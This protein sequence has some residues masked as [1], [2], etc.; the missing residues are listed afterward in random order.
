MEYGDLLCGAL[1]FLPTIM[2][3]PMGLDIVEPLS[4][5]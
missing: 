1:A 3:A 2:S 4:Y 5:A